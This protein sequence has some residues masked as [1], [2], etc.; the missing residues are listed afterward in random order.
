MQ[1]QRC[2]SRG[3]KAAWASSGIVVFRGG[4]TKTLSGKNGIFV[5]SFGEVHEA[6]AVEMEEGTTVVVVVV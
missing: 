2:S 1:K 3:S 4:N 5:C 6:T